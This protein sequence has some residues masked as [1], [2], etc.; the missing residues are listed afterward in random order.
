MH[1]NLVVAR[2]PAIPHRLA[3]APVAGPG[4]ADGGEGQPQT[5]WSGDA[6]RTE[7]GIATL[8]LDL[9]TSQNE[10]HTSL[11]ILGAAPQSLD[12]G[13]RVHHYVVLLL[14]RRRLDDARRC[15][16]PD[17]CGWIGIEQ[18]ANMLGIDG[19]YLNILIHRVRAQFAA[20]LGCHHARPD[21]VERRR[22][23]VRLGLCR[24]R[25]VRGSTSEGEFVPGGRPC[26]VL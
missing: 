13:E 8:V 10:E 3:P 1:V 11:R 2:P 20:A 4:P 22:G 12:L 19:A 6:A 7:S 17:S 21:P 18:L 14:A 15:F 26:N 24:F 23:E 5:I 16:E 9:H 25:I